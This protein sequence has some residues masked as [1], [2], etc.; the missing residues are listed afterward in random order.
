MLSLR[1]ST[2]PKAKNE[3]ANPR[4]TNSL[5]AITAQRNASFFPK[6]KTEARKPYQHKGYFLYLSLDRV[7]VL[8][9]IGLCGF[10]AILNCRPNPTDW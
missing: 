10:E 2:A 1:A 3:Q 4:K 9:W 6:G 8:S 7:I 5:R